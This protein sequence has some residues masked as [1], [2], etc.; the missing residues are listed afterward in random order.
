M[1]SIKNLHTD[2]SEKH[3]CN[4]SNIPPILGGIKGGK[5]ERIKGRK[6]GFTLVELIVTITI[7]AILW[8]IA[9]TAF[10]GFQSSARDSSRASDLANLS[11]AF[12]TSYIKTGSYP[13]PDNSFTVTYSGWSLWYQWTVWD[14]LINILSSNGSKLSKKPTDPLAPSREYTYSKSAYGNTYEL[15]SNWE[16]DRIALNNFIPQAFAASG[17]PTITYIKGNYNGMVAK[18]VTGSTV[19]VIATPSLTTSTGTVWSSIDVTTLS[20]KLL[21]HGQTNSGWIAFTPTLI[22]SSWS[23][24]INNDSW[25]ITLFTTNLQTAYSGSVISSNSNISNVLTTTGATNIT[26]LWASII[27]NYLGW[28]A[29][30]P[31][32]PPATSYNISNSLMFDSASAQYLSR[33]PSVAGNRKKWTWSGWVKKSWQWVYI[34]PFWSYNAGSYF[35]LR[36]EAGDNIFLTDVASGI[37]KISLTTSQVFRDPSAWYHIVVSVDTTQAANNVKLYVNGSEITNFIS[38]TYPVQNYDTQFNTPTLSYVWSSTANGSIFYHFNGY[39]AD[40]NFVDSGALDPTSFGYTDPTTNQWL[41]K[42]YTGTY[43]TNGFHLDFSSGALTAGSNVGLGKDS[44]GN[45]NYWNTNWITDPTLNQVIDTPLNNFATLNPLNRYTEYGTLNSNK[46]NLSTTG[47]GTD[48]AQILGTIGVSTGKWY[49][50]GKLTST[51]GVWA[52]HIWFAATPLRL[53]WYASNSGPSI[54]AAV[55]NWASYDG[56]AFLY[57]SSSAGAWGNSYTTGDIIGIALDADTGKIWFSKNNTWQTGDPSTGTLPAT[58]LATGST[59]MPI[60]WWYQSGIW[61]ANFWQWWQS[62]L[63]N[64]PDAGGYFKFQPPTG[65]KALSTANLPTPTIVNPKQYF[66]VLTWT[67]NGLLNNQIIWLSFQPDFVWLKSRSSGNGH[68]LFDSV[69]WAG[70]FISSSS[71]TNEL[72]NTQYFWPFLNNGFNLS[73]S[74]VWGDTNQNGWGYVAWNWKAGWTAV[75]NTAWTIPSQVSANPTAGFSIVSYTGNGVNGATVAHGLSQTPEFI[76]EKG[77]DSAYSWTVQ[78][79]WAWPQSISGYT[80]WQNSLFLNNTGSINPNSGNG[81][82]TTSVFKPS[83]LNYQNESAKKYIAY[84]FHSVPGYSKFWTYTGNGSNDGVFVYT[85]FRPR[86]IMS[87]KIDTVSV[88]GGVWHIYDTERWTYNQISPYLQAQSP[89]IEGSPAEIDILSNWFK[90]RWASINAAYDHNISGATYIYAA[91]AEA[92]FKYANAR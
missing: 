31:P 77:R 90:F 27:T 18:T 19:Y 16:W 34:S 4:P 74:L 51:Y 28:S 11:Q 9:F 62:G 3:L 54:S 67:G 63:T 49:F 7:I 40:V 82:P 41:P 70:K 37:T 75:A 47:G 21:Y 76:I 46:G 69:R 60:L 72:D 39:L 38:P 86:W 83:A 17:N 45:G 73:P 56:R 55:N 81:A 14:T 29:S 78:A 36:F 24:P 89:N 25:Q 80:G 88:T 42:Q 79:G 10:N 5:W 71:T 15:S 64:Y 44:S 58:I 35:L 85:G 92:P 33:T 8:A 65:F 91:F 13:N 22:Y 30:A 68:D 87:K 26:S 1:H 12:D 61:T 32:P 2:V 50:E 59:W 23:L 66:D 43:G 57:L 6:S 52:S 84:V 53:S 48:F 20:G